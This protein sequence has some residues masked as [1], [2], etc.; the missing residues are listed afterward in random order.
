[1]ST[2]RN[3]QVIVGGFDEGINRGNLAYFDDSIAPNYVNHNMPTPGPGPEGLKAVIQMFQIAF[4]DFHVT[5]E[6]ALAEG[7]RV[8]TRGYFTGTHREEF[9]GIPATGKSVRVGYTDI[10]RLEDGKAVENWVQMDMMGMLQ[11]LGVIPAPG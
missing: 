2:E 6:E 8:C 1:M 4:P 9:N 7:D 10:W 11:Q 3:R 5:V